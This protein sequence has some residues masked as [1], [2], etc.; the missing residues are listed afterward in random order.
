MTD[1]Q[2]PTDPRSSRPQPEL[3]Q[4]KKLI[5]AL[6]T[7]LSAIFPRANQNEAMATSVINDFCED[8][9]YYSVYKIEEAFRVY[10]TSPDANFFPTPGQIIKL[11]KRDFP[12]PRGPAFN[13]AQLEPPGLPRTLPSIP[14]ILRKNGELA[15]ADYYE[16][17]GALMQKR[18]GPQARAR[19]IELGGKPMTE[20]EG[21][22]A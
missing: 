11:I 1:E 3:L 20:Y 10:R 15:A 22:Q 14:D 8:L 5:A 21:V 2:L 19:L 13:A 12:A 18:L 9:Q 7:K 17:N 6:L 4:K 16:E